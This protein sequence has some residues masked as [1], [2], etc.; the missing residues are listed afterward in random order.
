MQWPLK[1]KKTLRSNLI[2][3]ENKKMNDY[4]AKLNALSGKLAGVGIGAVCEKPIGGFIQSTPAT[5]VTGGPLALQDHATEIRGLVSQV[6]ELRA[7]LSK[8]A[9]ECFNRI[10]VL[11]MKVGN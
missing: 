3:L 9:E 8:V 5:P 6:G 2:I 1:G 7:M 4:N 11:E 10:N